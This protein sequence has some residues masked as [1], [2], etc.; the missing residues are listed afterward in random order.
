M[1]GHTKEE[2]D[3]SDGL[4]SNLIH[5]DQINSLSQSH[6]MIWT[7]IPVVSFNF[8]KHSRLPQGKKVY[9]TK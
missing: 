8:F 6:V 3:M 5:L 9:N 4:R 7:N 2:K 1:K